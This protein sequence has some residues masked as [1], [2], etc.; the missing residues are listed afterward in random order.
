VSEE[1]SI[2]HELLDEYGDE[3]A[4]LLSLLRRILICLIL[5]TLAVFLVFSL[6]P[7]DEWFLSFM[8]GGVEVEI[9]ALEPYIPLTSLLELSLCLALPIV[10]TYSIYSI[11][12]YLK[13]ALL[14][15]EYS[16]FKK[17]FLSLVVLSLIGYVYGILVVAPLNLKFLILVG[18]TLLADTVE[19]TYSLSSIV[20]LWLWASILTSVLFMVPRV[21]KILRDLGF[22]IEFDRRIVYGLLIICI[23]ILDPD[24]FLFTEF[25]VGVPVII[26]IEL[27]LR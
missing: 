11:A 27:S 1:R 6:T 14:E 20:D 24:P 7:L 18:K 2:I 3:I 9:I 10:L 26:A 22:E 15:E 8:V 4:E 5:S 13:P 21:L 23:S 19:S 25:L 12:E 16:I 17:Y